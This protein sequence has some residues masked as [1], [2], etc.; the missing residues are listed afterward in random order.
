MFQ[1]KIPL[2]SL[3]CQGARRRFKSRCTL[4]QVEATASHDSDL[5]LKLTAMGSNGVQPCASFNQFKVSP[6]FRVD[7]NEN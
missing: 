1:V 2:A 3:R 5:R 7:Y 6:F 4:V